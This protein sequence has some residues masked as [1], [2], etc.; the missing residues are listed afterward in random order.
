MSKTLTN[1]RE[2][3]ELSLTDRTLY[4][5][6]IFF[7]GILFGTAFLFNTPAEIW[8]GNLIILTSPANLITDYFKIANIGAALTNAAIMVVQA[9]IIIKRSKAQISGLLGGNF[10]GCGIFVIW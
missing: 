10:Y 4:L 9:I 1:K 7:A 3:G 8:R 5:C 2:K 6:F